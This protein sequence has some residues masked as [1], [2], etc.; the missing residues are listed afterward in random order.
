MTFTV[1]YKPSAEQELADIWINAPDRQAVTNAANRIDRLLRTDP[2]E[3]GEARDEN[4][5]VLV[6]S[7]LAV[8]FEI[9]AD[10]YQVEVLRVRWV[11]Q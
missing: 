6:E 4:I 8:Q 3:L 7:P 5:R 1:T 9:H 10:D 11:G 2:E